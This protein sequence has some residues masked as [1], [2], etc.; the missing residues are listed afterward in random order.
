MGNIHLAKLLRQDCAPL[1]FGVLA[2][3]AR[4]I[5]GWGEMGPVH[6][7]AGVLASRVVQHARGVL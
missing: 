3:T 2:R 4:R 7:F 1:Y 6:T 5:S